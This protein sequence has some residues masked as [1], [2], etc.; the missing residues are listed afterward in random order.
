MAERGSELTT[1]VPAELP[2]SGDSPSF[3]NHLERT[4]PKAVAAAALH[5]VAIPL[6]AGLVGL[7]AFGIAGFLPASA[8]GFFGA[9]SFLNWIPLIGN[10]TLRNNLEQSLGPK[11]GWVFV[12]LR[13]SQGSLVQEARRVETD[14]N[15]GF[16]RTTDEA[17]EVTTEGGALSVGRDMIR[18]FSTERMLGLPYLQYIRV[19][20]EEDGALR[21][22]LFVSR[23]GGSVEQHRKNTV[24]LHDRLVEWHADHQLKW[25]DA[26]R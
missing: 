19:E 17:L 8:L 6:A 3:R 20:F 13:A 1:S 15:V 22:F 9:L 26:H 2:T 11:Q 14:D 21:S 12:G 23:E 4:A 10:R 16:L 18:G 7:L 24:A 25:L 5:T